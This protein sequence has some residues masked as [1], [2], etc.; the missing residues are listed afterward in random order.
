ML[1]GNQFVIFAERFF[2]QDKY[3]WGFSEN[4]WIISDKVKMRVDIKRL[5]GI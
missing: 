2:V 4:S 3:F 1:L 5:H